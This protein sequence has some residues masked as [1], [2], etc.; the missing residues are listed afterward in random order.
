MII[1]NLKNEK[2]NSDTSIKKVFNFFREKYQSSEYF[3]KED[4]KNITQWDKESTFN[5]YF[6]KIFKP[7]LLEHE[8]DK[9]QV[10]ETFRN[11]SSFNKFKRHF[12]QTRRM[13]DDFIKERYETVTIYEF[14]MP[15]T[16]EGNLRSSLDSLFYK[17]AIINRLKKTPI[18]KIKA[19]FP[20]KENETNDQYYE[21]ICNWISNKFIGYSI[22]HFQGRFRASTLKS[23]E[24]VAEI[25]KKAE[26]YIIDETTAIVKF[27]F[28]L[29]DPKSNAV[30]QDLTPFFTKYNEKD[31][32]IKKEIDRLWFLFN[33]LFIESI[34]QVVS[35]E[36][37]IWM[38][39]S[40]FITRLHKWKLE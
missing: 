38:L 36:A 10:G 3:T 9:Y 14:Y 30:Q 12:S 33:I 2:Y 6:T 13:R 24:E 11:L 27:I 23:F 5:T 32:Q 25:Q 16:N 31:T 1:L 29:G 18:E 20:S 26:K 15:L 28:P 19:F 40:G 21:R 17:D 8:K 39:E 7:L 22:G 37:E 4:L 34:L 35:G